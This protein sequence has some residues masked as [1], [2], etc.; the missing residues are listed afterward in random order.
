MTFLAIDIGNTRLKWAQYASPQ[1]GATLLRHGAVFLE[2]IDS[3]A[4]RDWLALPA[5]G[6]MLGCVVAGEGV[7]RRVEEQ[8]EIWDLEPRWVVSSKQACGVVNSYDHPS[9]LG[10]DRWVALI[11]ARRRVLSSRVFAPRIEAPTQLPWETSTS[12]NTKPGTPHAGKI[13]RPS[14]RLRD[15]LH[16]ALAVQIGRA[17]CRERVYGRV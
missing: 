10:V 17:S 16:F 8:L 13:D 15:R 6:S 5:P 4:E 12:A 11:G 1:P 2:T 7:K 9:R 3:L 14:G